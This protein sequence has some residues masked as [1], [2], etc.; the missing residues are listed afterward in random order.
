M[1]HVPASHLPA[2]LLRKAVTAAHRRLGP[3]RSRRL[4]R[5]L[6]AP[7][8]RAT[9]NLR[10][11]P[12]APAPGPR[13]PASTVQRRSTGRPPLFFHI[14]APKSGTTYLQRILWHNREALRAAGVLYPGESFGAHVQAAFDLRGARFAD[15]DDPGVAGRWRSFVDQA[16]AWDGPA[17]FSQELFSPAGPAQI[18]AAMVDLDFAEVHVVYTARELSKQIPAA[19]QEDVKNRFTVR[20]DEFVAAVKDTERDQHGLGAMFWR[21]QD[22]VEVLARWSQA[23]PPERVH[24]VTV[25]PQ[26]NPP[27]E[28]WRRFCSVLRIAPDLV[29]LSQAF[30][31]SSLGAAEATVLRRLNLA[32]AD[33]VGWPLYN[34]LVKHH[35]AQNVLV[36]R[37]HPITIGLPAGER[38]WVAQR[39]RAMVDGLR[40]AGYDIVGSLEDLLPGPSGSLAAGDPDDPPLADQLDVAVDALAGLLLRI[41][42][43]RRGVPR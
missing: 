17:V 22:A 5:A 6:P 13:L 36:E 4:V 10:L 1:S 16:R 11:A 20:F 30:Q 37:A 29:D 7:L 18:E 28:L 33:E 12:P 35:I 19:W 31:N 32:L 9:V 25:P 43:N 23:L 14:G 2:A 39:S 34:E 24:V 26:R 27:D 40:H 38:E 8:A 15:F 3:E 41:S 42:R 21:M